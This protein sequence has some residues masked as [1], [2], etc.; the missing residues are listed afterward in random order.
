MA[1]LEALEIAEGARHIVAM[2]G[3]IAMHEAKTTGAFGERIPGL[4]GGQRELDPLGS[5]GNLTVDF[6]LEGDGFE[7]NYFVS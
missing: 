5:G 1:F 3:F 6:A 2:A 7:S 4:G